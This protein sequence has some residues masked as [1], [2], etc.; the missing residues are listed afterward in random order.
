MNE[1]CHDKT[2][3]IG[4]EES[5]CSFPKPK[6]RFVPTGTSHHQFVV[7]NTSANRNLIRSLTRGGMV[8]PAFTSVGLV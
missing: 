1:T 2:T 3:E 8:I 5:L 7:L 6:V 4:F